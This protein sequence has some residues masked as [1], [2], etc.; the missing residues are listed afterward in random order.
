MGLDIIMRCLWQIRKLFKQNLRHTPDWRD[1]EELWKDLG[2]VN[3]KPIVSTLSLPG[4]FV[5]YL[6]LLLGIYGVRRGTIEICQCL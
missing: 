4:T 3:R 2:A 1:T 5:L 6:G